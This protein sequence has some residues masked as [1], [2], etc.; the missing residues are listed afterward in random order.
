MPFDPS[1]VSTI[2]VDSYSTLVDVD[3]VEEALRER[4]EDPEAVSRLWR[5]R[6]L[7]YTMVAN[8][9]DEYQPFFEMNRDALEYALDAHDVD[10]STDERDEILDTYHDLEVFEDVREGIERLRDGGYDVYVLSNGNPA[11]LESMVEG[12]EI[13]DLLSGVI[14]ADE[15]E[16]FKPDR[17]LYRHAAARTGTPVDELAHVSAV[18]FDVQGAQ[19]AGAQGVW[20]DRKGLPWEPFGSEPD[21]TVETFY[22]LAEELGV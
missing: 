17:E 15:V 16:T 4:V 10:I 5:S 11:M 12:A 1:R 3:S 8:H 6:S 2:T 22:D 21:L 19:Y 20:A 7:E 9:L 18:W 13:G 14:S